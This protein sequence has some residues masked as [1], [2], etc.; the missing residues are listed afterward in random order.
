MARDL[1]IATVFQNLA[2]VDARDVAC[3]LFLGREPTRWRYF[4]DKRKMREDARKVV[5][6]LEVENQ[7]SLVQLQL[8][9]AESAQRGY[10]ATLRPDFQALKKMAVCPAISFAIRI[11]VR[12]C[13]GN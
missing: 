7:I 4:V 12:A 10:L 11:D 6:T 3:N 1:G 2:L 5:R 9:R 13:S 8:R